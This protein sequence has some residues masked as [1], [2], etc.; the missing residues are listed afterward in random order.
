MVDNIEI[1]RIN[2]MTFRELRNELAN[3]MNNP[4][5]GTII[6]NLMYIRYNQHLYKKQQLEQFR[7]EAKRKQ[8]LQIKNKLEKKYKKNNEIINHNHSEEHYDDDF[9]SFKKEHCKDVDL[10]ENDFNDTKPLF[11]SLNEL[12]E[13]N[14]DLFDLRDIT[15]Y[16][17]DH[18]NN[19]LMDR[20]NVDMDLHN[21]KVKTKN[22][23]VMPYSNDIG[24]YASF[25][26]NNNLK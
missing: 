1:A 20:L 24:S 19:N 8:I 6:R 17:R 22:D 13:D 21:I 12:D 10:N 25:H 3:C 2:K 9:G 16:E 26:S 18:A 11:G 7:K 5:R 14:S 23:F 4:V 15:E